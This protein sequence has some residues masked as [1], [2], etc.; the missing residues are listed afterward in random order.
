MIVD[1]PTHL[2]YLSFI[3][4]HK[5]EWFTDSDI[6]ERL[7][8]TRK[9]IANSRVKCLEIKILKGLFIRYCC[10]R[11]QTLYMYSASHSNYLSLDEKKQP[12]D[13]SYMLYILKSVNST[14]VVQAILKINTS[15]W[16]ISQ[17]AEVMGI[18]STE[19]SYRLKAIHNRNKHHFSLHTI[20]S[21]Q[22]ERLY[23]AVEA[24]KPDASKEVV[25][26]DSTSKLSFSE[27]L[28]KVFGGVF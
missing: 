28:S 25:G 26:K 22:K 18:N 24:V 27:A 5:T 2:R 10:K 4:E 21:N 8:V 6:A 20:L 3:K 7:K 11:K 17:L 9:M 1:T 14:E 23:L 12:S 16:S 19:A 13:I 15:Y